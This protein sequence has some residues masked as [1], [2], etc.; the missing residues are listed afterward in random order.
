MQR[1]SVPGVVVRQPLGLDLGHVDIRRA[2]RLAGLAGEAEVQHLMHA[3]RRELFLRQGSGQRRPE[4]V[5]PAAGRMLLVHGGVIGGAHGSGHALAAD[6]RA[7]AHLDGSREPALGREIQFGV[8]GERPVIAAPPEIPGQVGS[9]HDLARIQDVPR[10]E[11]PLE[12]Q[13]PLVD[14]VAEQPAV[15]PATRDPVAMLARHGTAMIH[16]QPE[17][18]VGD[19]RHLPHARRVFQVDHRAH[20]QAADRGVAVIAAVRV[21]LLE[22]FAKAFQETPHAFDRH[23]RVLHESDRLVVSL[24]RHQ[25]AEGFLPDAPDLGL[26]GRVPDRQIAVADP[27]GREQGLQPLQLRGDFRLALAVI[28]DD[29]HRLRVAVHP[30]EL[31]RERRIGAG[32]VENELVDQLRR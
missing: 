19:R 32:V 23:R 2:F 26:P 24:H 22:D 11:R 1:R 17:D 21:V 4:R 5:G 7:V 30:V 15:V 20:V 3:G 28:L 18:L 10:V 8:D 16:H 12:F 31:V 6:A 9:V 13:E 29:Q 25:D 14:P 27:P